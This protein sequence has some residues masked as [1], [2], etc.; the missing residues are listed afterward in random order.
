MKYSVN[1]SNKINLNDFDEIIIKYEDQNQEL[2][3]FLEEH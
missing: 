3:D 1:Y 2:I